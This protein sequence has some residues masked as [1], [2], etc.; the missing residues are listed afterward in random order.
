MRC[1]LILRDL[2]NTSSNCQEVGAWQE[3]N[4]TPFACQKLRGVLN[5][6]QELGVVLADHDQLGKVNVL[7]VALVFS[8]VEGGGFAS[9][10]LWGERGAEWLH[11]S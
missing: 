4:G 1:P 2:P 8:Q 9:I 10:I 6:C 7:K 3:P 11:T 5:A